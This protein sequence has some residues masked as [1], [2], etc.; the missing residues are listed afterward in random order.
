MLVHAHVILLEDDLKWD[1]L[2]II[3]IHSLFICFSILSPTARLKSPYSRLVVSY[4][5]ESCL[6]G[7]KVVRA[8][9]GDLS[10]DVLNSWNKQNE[11]GESDSSA[12]C[13]ANSY[14]ADLRNFRKIAFGQ[15][16]TSSDYGATS[17]YGLNPSCSSSELESQE[18]ATKKH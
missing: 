5:T 14:S 9:E 1:R 8:L 3:Y 13:G 17:E 2:K 7:K 16:Y 6:I 18:M 11:G 10:L 4:T 12:E 15:E